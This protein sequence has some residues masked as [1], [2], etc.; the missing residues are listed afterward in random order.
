MSWTRW[1]TDL[2][3]STLSHTL[4]GLSEIEA[5]MTDNVNKSC[6]AL[7]SRQLTATFTWWLWRWTC[8]RPK[9]WGTYGT[10]WS[11]SRRVNFKG[12]KANRAGPCGAL[13]LVWMFF[14]GRIVYFQK[15]GRLKQTGDGFNHLVSVWR[16]I[17]REEIKIVNCHCSF[18]SCI[19]L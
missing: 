7:V 19:F 3:G 5:M 12:W 16:M 15:E 14:R 1:I 10:S 6:M 2:R 11:K 17:Q 8:A 13:P 4:S 18:W 9:K